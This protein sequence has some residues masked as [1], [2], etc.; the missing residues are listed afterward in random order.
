MG[1][2]KQHCEIKMKKGECHPIFS[3]AYLAENI[4][5]FI[6]TMVLLLEASLITLFLFNF[7]I[8]LFNEYAL[9]NAAGIFINAISINVLSAFSTKSTTLNNF[10]SLLIMLSIYVITHTYFEFVKY[11]LHPRH[12]KYRRVTDTP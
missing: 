6:E 1:N 4:A 11:N 7:L 12:I 3:T 2:I 9:N 10:L 8:N 5:S